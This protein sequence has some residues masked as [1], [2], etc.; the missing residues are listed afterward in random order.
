VCRDYPRNLMWQPDP[1]LL[2]PCG[3]RP[4]APNAAGLRA[5]LDRLDLTPAQREKL[6]RGLRLDG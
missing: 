4:I 3:Y 2:P 6:R 1:E 5:A